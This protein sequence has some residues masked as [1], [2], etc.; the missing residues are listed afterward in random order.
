LQL[1]QRAKV[2]KVLL[3]ESNKPHAATNNGVERWAGVEMEKL[4]E[5]RGW[6]HARTKDLVFDNINRLAGDDEWVKQ[7]R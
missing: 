6:Q 3:A 1:R 5:L 4:S 7:L 2:Q